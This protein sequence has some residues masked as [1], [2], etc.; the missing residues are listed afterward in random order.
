MRPRSLPWIRTETLLLASALPH[1]LGG[2]T[3]AL[4]ANHQW[5]E[6]SYPSPMRLDETL[7]DAWTGF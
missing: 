4:P 3:A 7:F 1:T 5:Q 6:F 2:E